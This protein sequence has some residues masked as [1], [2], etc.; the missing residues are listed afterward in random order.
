MLEIKGKNKAN[1]KIYQITITLLMCMFQSIVHAQTGKMNGTYAWD[2]TEFLTISE[3][4]FKLYLYP[5]YPL[6]YGLN[7]GDTI[8]AEGKIHYESDNFIKLTSKDYDW[9]A[10]KNMTVNESVNSCLN[11]SIRFNFI[12]PFNGKYKILLYLGSDSKKEVEYEF[13][14]KKEF[15][16]PVRQDSLLTFSFSIW[17]QT[18]TKFPYHN[19]LKTIRFSSFRHTAKNSNSNSFEISIPDLTNSYFN[20]YLIEG[21]YIRVDKERD[22]L[23]WHNEKYTRFGR[24]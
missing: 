9:E 15:I 13:D 4:S 24:R 12:F 10:K 20:R 21:D 19:Y 2:L 7:W 22:V 6:L 5:T 17:N 18:P 3:D 14:D 1:M 23:F 16:F 8:L 11:D